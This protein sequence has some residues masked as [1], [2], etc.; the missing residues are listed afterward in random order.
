MAVCQPQ[1][2][3]ISLNLFRFV[4]ENLAMVAAMFGEI[5]LPAQLSI[6]NSGGIT[7]LFCVC[8]DLYFVELLC[9]NIQTKGEV[10]CM[11]FM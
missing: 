3:V 9:F 11:I 10:P 5:P 8:F 2:S 1:S 4:S 6:E 7:P